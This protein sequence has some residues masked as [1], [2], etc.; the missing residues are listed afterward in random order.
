MSKL[1]KAILAIVE[2]F[3]EYAGTD[4]KKTQLSNAELAQLI[5]SQ[6]SSPEFKDKVDPENI[7]DVM[8]KLDKNHDGEVNFNEFS[9]CVAGLARAYFQKMHGKEKGKGRGRGGQDK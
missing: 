4:D 8:D 5:K 2:V 6:L 9:Q 3:E 7:K 1:E